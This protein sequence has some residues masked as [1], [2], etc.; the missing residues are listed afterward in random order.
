[1]TW[2]EHRRRHLL[3]PGRI[4]RARDVTPPLRA[5]GRRCSGLPAELRGTTGHAAPTCAANGPRTPAVMTHPSSFRRLSARLAVAV[6]ALAVAADCA[7]R[8]AARTTPPYDGAYLVFRNNTEDEVRV[9]VCAGDRRW[10]AGNVQAFRRA[11]LHVATDLETNPGQVVGLAAVPVGGR[12]RDGDPA[13]GSVVL[14]DSEL[15]D[16]ITQFD[17]TLSGHS[18]SATPTSRPRR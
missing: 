12:G 11:R 18:L 2:G 3:Y 10:F 8:S 9:F 13:S 6:S 1:M 16:R 4:A 15:A 17:W 14:S 5:E 7:G